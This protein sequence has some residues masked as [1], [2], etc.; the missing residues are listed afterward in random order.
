M[1]QTKYDFPSMFAKV[2]TQYKSFPR[3]AAMMSTLLT[4]T[5]CLIFLTD[6]LSF[7]PVAFSF[8]KV[9][10]RAST[11]SATSF[12]LL[13]QITKPTTLVSSPSNARASVRPLF[14]ETDTK[15]Q[16]TAAESDVEC[17]VPEEE[18]SESK[19]LLQKVKDAGIAGGIRYVQ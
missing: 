10:V 14:A 2:Q 5:V 11:H 1:K 13:T 15:E 6:A 3:P 7:S 4:L 9:A 19:K 16:L 18:M 8:R 12:P 17:E